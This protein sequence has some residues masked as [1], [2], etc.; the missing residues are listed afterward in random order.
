MRYLLTFTYLRKA[1]GEMKNNI[2]TVMTVAMAL[3]AL[4][5]A[6]MSEIPDDIRMA[7][8]LRPTTVSKV[9]RRRMK[10]VTDAANG[11]WRRAPSSIVLYAYYA[12]INVRD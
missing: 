11:E 8:L 2:I 3:A 9:L 1:V 10:K 6:M 7:R 5:A 4:Q 12:I